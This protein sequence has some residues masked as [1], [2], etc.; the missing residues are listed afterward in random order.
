MSRGSISLGRILGI[1]VRVDL[2]WLF[3]VVWMTWSL[4]GSYFPARH[5]TW[6]LSLT[7]AMAALTNV[8]FFGS[9]LLHELGHSLVARAL[10]LPVTDITLFIFGGASQITDEPRSPRDELLL[11]GVGPAT[12]LGLAG[13]FGLGHL[14]ARSASEPLADITLFLA[15]INLSLGLFN[16]IPGFP[17][18]GG[19]MLRAVLWGA[20]RDAR[21]ATRWA[22]RS[23][24]AIAGLFVL[25]G[26]YRASMGDWVGGL[27]VV[28]IG[29]FLDAASRSSYQQLTLRQLLDGHVAA[30]VMS[31]E[32]HPVP[33]QL[34]L[35]VFVEHYLVGEGARRCYIVG[36][37]ENLV[38][39]LTLGDLQKVPRNQWLTTHLRDI[40]MPLE[41]LRVVAPD[42]PLWTA[43]QQMTAEGVNQ[44]PVI[45]RG[46]M[47][48][49][50]SRDR[51]LS[52]I[53]RLSELEP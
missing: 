47:V 48:G 3:I 21:W 13:V 8:L 6:P 4:A 11:A 19:R 46:E 38:G 37:E 24:R 52:L 30:E 51:L 9:V 7:L 5:P 22:S 34:T 23:G 17:L 29:F 40:A 43:L 27:W 39:L 20:R 15:G 25:L 14:A 35:D 50:I 36:T 2:S 16:L 28:F 44:M 31:K 26:I 45:D 12:N 42:T 33:P 1:P 32:C 53:R 10:R 49:M 41:H 18:D